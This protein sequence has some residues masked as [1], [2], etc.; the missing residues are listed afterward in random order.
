MCA[1]RF[2]FERLLNEVEYLYA[3]N[4]FISRP[5]EGVQT[6]LLHSVRLTHCRSALLKAQKNPP[7]QKKL[8]CFALR[9][10]LKFRLFITKVLSVN[11][12]PQNFGVFFCFLEKRF[13]TLQRCSLSRPKLEYYRGFV[14]HLSPLARL[15]GRL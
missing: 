5:S 15:G 10:K 7:G 12:K 3:Q 1:R 13:L 8:Y 11:S 6:R 14:H 9:G 2:S 4:P